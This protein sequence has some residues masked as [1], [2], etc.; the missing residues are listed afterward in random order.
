MPRTFFVTQD[1]WCAWM[2]VRVPIGKTTA[3]FS[4]EK[5]EYLLEVNGKTITIKDKEQTNTATINADGTI[6]MPVGPMMLT[7][8]R[9]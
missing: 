4:D 9:G 2:A 7:L 6:T 8:K 1:F 3:S 5:G